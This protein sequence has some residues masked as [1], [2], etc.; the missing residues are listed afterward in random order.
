MS[1]G[2]NSAEIE[3]SAPPELRGGGKDEGSEWGR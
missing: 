2:G 3:V 1:D